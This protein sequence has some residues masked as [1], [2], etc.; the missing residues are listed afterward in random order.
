MSTFFP[1][2]QPE[3]VL[4]P[5]DRHRPS[6]K[7]LK[8]EATASPVHDSVESGK[9][10]VDTRPGPSHLRTHG[11]DGL[12]QPPRGKTGKG[13]DVSGEHSSAGSPFPRKL[14]DATRTT[15]TPQCIPDEAVAEFT[16]IVRAVRSANPDILLRDPIALRRQETPSEKPMDDGDS[17]LGVF[18]DFT[19]LQTPQKLTKSRLDRAPGEGFFNLSTLHSRPGWNDESKVATT[20]G[21]TLQTG[22][23]NAGS[24]DSSE[25][26]MELPLLEMESYY[27]FNPRSTG[28]AFHLYRMNDD[29]THTK[30]DFQVS[31]VPITLIP[32]ETGGLSC[33][34]GSSG[35][36]RNASASKSRE[37]L[38]PPKSGE[39]IS[40]TFQAMSSGSTGGSTKSARISRDTSCTPGVESPSSLLGDDV[41]G[42]GLEIP[43]N[44][45]TKVNERL[46]ARR[47]M[48]DHMHVIDAGGKHVP[49]TKSM[50]LVGN[51]DIR[52]VVGIVVQEMRQSKPLTNTEGED[53]DPKPEDRS[54][55]RLDGLANMILPPPG[56]LA[57]PA[58]TISLPRTSYA[59]QSASDLQVHTKI[60]G[61]D[62]ETTTT[63]ISRKSVA[64]IT[65]PL[66]QCP[67]HSIEVCN[68]SS[69]SRTV[70]ECSSPTHRASTT[71]SSSH[72]QS[73]SVLAGGRSSSRLQLSTKQEYERSHIVPTTAISSVYRRLGHTTCRN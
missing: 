20:G 31:Q 56:T 36:D 73:Q 12:P 25:P 66:T 70:S 29:E 17:P 18:P 7:L 45:M 52:D 49:G 33:E 61:E 32:H 54:L 21:D 2:G 22:D 6:S 60:R 42:I 48:R 71:Y 67:G 5:P 10:A 55:P 51:K 47:H 46:E 13:E 63:I 11:T 24:T 59:S 41:G 14:S 1:P 72:R 62:S 27:I 34:I 57:D 38:W 44:I 58:T 69:Y 65:W 64:Q 43:P 35:K 50:F 16:K 53:T 68:T 39:G 8:R 40:N 19:P 30:T 37:M 9:P 28:P 3:I 4:Y 15:T 23:L 26:P